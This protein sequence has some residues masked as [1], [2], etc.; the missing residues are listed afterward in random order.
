MKEVAKDDVLGI[1][2]RGSYNTIAC[3]PAR[4]LDSQYSLNTVDLCPVGALTSSDFRFK[5]R[6]WFLKETRSICTSCATGCNTIIG[7]RE[8]VVYRQT[9][10]ENNDVNQTWM[11]DHGRLNFHYL[12]SSDRLLGPLVKDVKEYEEAPDWKSAIARTGAA[13][14]PFE[15]NQV[16]IIASG[17]NTNEELFLVSRLAATLGTTQ[18]DIVPHVDA[19]DDILLSADR[20]PNT[21]GAKLLGVSAAI[22]GGKLHTIVEGIRSGTIKALVVLGEDAVEAGISEADLAK[23][24]VLVAVNILPIRTT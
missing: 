9:P 22:P 23:L 20:N 3:H 15:G 5:M 11:C 6:V 17:R 21:V 16:A 7:S 13:L 18:H 19:G 8:N 24:D 1:V 2:N 14:K 12:H 4:A 10:R